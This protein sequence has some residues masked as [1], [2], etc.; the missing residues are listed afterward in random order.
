MIRSRD[1]VFNEKVM[2]KDRN[3]Q[4]S[5]PEEPEYFGP[6]DV[7]ENRVLEPVNQN[8]EEQGEPEC[9][10]EAYQGKDASKW[11]LAMKDEMKSLISNQTWEL[12]K[13][14]EGKKALQ[15]KWVFRIKEEHDGSKRYKARLVV[16]GFQQIEGID[17]SEIF[18]P[19]VKLTTIRLVL[20][21]VAAKGLYLEQLDEKTAFLHRDL[22]EEIY[23]QQPEGFAEDGKEELVCRLT[24]SLYSLKQASR[25]WYKKFDGFMQG[26][27][28]LRCNADHC[29]Y[30]KKVK[31]SFIIG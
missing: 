8:D 3:T 10:D 16:K 21:I 17:Y 18:S 14:P 7:S 20:S 1:V 2:Y 9:Y 11:E 6:N 4:V 30:F 29:C 23:M 22:E 27:G 19:V 31:S 5:E 26:N 28:Y 15:N 24:K 25:Q 12:A 13:L